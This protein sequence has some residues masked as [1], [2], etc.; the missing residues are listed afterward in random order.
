VSSRHMHDAGN[1]CAGIMHV[2]IYAIHIILAARSTISLR[3]ETHWNKIG[4]VFHY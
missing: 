1:T 2:H 3:Y 4:Q